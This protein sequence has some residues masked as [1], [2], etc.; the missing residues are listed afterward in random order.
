MKRIFYIIAGFIVFLLVYTLVEYLVIGAL[1][2]KLIFIK[3]LKE[4]VL[5]CA[6]L[7]IL[8]LFCYFTINY[9]NN[10]FIVKKLNKKIENLKMER[11]NTNDEK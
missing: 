7:Y 8:I 5:H 6:F 2:M 9:I 3:L 4:Y 11:R 1:G 10:F